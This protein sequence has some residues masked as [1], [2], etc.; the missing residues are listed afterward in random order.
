MKLYLTQILKEANEFGFSQ[1]PN[2]GFSTVSPG[3]QMPLQQQQPPMQQQP[4]LSMLQNPSASNMM[5]PG[6]SMG[7]SNIQIAGPKFTPTL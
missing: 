6:G 4:Q 5:L 7:Q 2:V 3:P 1:Q